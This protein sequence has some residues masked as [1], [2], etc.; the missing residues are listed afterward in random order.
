MPPRARS[1]GG[2]V[3]AL[4]A[5]RASWR[6]PGPGGLASP[7]GTGRRSARDGRS[8]PAGCSIARPSASSRAAC[9]LRHACHVPAK[10]RERVG[11]PAA[12]ASSSSTAVPTVS[13]NQRSW[14]TSTIAASR[15]T[16]VCSNHSRDSMSRWLV[17]SSSSST[18]APVASARAS[19]AR[20]SWP[21]EKV[22]RRA[23]EV[24]V[25]EAQ[26]VDHRGGTVAPAVA[27]ARLQPRL[28]AAVAAQRGLVAATAGH[29]AARARLSSASM[30]SSSAQP[31]S[32]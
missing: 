32:T 18:S 31:D 14:A 21:P 23:V 22:S 16:S 30:A 15:P 20:V 25:D 19:D 12:P 13:R 17:G 9:S 26:P 7:L 2:R 8:P 5:G 24:G 6:A 4:H 11:W 3:D 1:R 10:K 27:A 29:R 28:R